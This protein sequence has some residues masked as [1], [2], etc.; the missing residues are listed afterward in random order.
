M[1]LFVWPDWWREGRGGALGLEGLFRGSTPSP[2]ILSL[3][4]VGLVRRCEKDIGVT[5]KRK[6]KV[7]IRL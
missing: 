2:A 3:S 5:V 6:V 1:Q 4:R 7:V